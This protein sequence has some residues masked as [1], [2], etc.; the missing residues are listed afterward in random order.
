MQAQILTTAKEIA[1]DAGKLAL[2]LFA[3][4]RELTQKGFRDF[5]TDADYAAQNLIVE[6]VREAFP[7]H[8]FLAEEDDATLSDD[9]EYVWII[10]PVDGTTNYSRHIPFFCVSIGIAKNGSP[11]VGVIYDPVRDELF[12]ATKG[13]GAFINGKPISVSKIDDLANAIVAHDW[14]RS[15]AM[16]D[17]IMDMLARLVHQT[18][19]IR[20]IGS[21]A[22]ALCWVANGRLDAYFNP[23][24]SAWDVA[25]GQLILEE[26]GGTLSGFNNEPFALDDPNSWSLATN[27]LIHTSFNPS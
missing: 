16:R 27:R 5:V 10:D 19:S 21:A 22:I 7:D 3:G 12:W 24:L 18:R 8:G 15:P 23:A 9:S 1:L 26:A 13:G 4:E 11:I 20:V 17:V 6:R 14:S 2:N 25:A